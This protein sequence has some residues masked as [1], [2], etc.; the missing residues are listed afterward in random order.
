MA[1]SANMMLIGNDRSLVQ[2][3]M[4]VSTLMLHLFTLTRSIFQ[5][6][7]LLTLLA[8]SV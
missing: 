8:S 4:P 3:L 6:L 2:S 1:A 5:K 7:E